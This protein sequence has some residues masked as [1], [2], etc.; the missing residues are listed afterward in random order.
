MNPYAIKGVCFSWSDLTVI[1][2]LS[3]SRLVYAVHENV[4]IG[5]VSLKNKIKY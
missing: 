2:L 5:G 3:L 4:L 1:F